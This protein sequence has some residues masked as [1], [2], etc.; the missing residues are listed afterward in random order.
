MGI[1]LEDAHYVVVRGLVVRG[2]RRG[3]QCMGQSRF[4]VFHDLHVHHNAIQG[5]YIATS[6][7]DEVDPTTNPDGCRGALDGRYPAC[8]LVQASR[9]HDSGCGCDSAG[10]QLMIGKCATNVWVRCCE[11]YFQD[12]ADRAGDGIT[13]ERASSGHLIEHCSFHDL[14]HLKAVSASLRRGP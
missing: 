1:H 14:P 10:T 4:V 11:F 6:D 5:L 2:F 7:S 8:I 12:T 13:F 9:F 3:V